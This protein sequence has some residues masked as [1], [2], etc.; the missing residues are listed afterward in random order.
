L[1]PYQLFEKKT[2]MYFRIISIL[3]ISFSPFCFLSRSV[4]ADL[5]AAW[6]FDEGSGTT[7]AAAF[8]SVNGTLNGSSSFVGTGISG[9]AVSLSSAGNGFVDMGNN[10]S[11]NGNTT[12]SIV[13]WVRLNQGDTNGYIVSGRHQATVV[14][15]YFLAVNN[16]GSGSG[17]VTGGG[18][19]YQSYPN[20]V[21]GNLGIND[22]NWHMLVG[23]HDFATS[24]SR[25]YVNG[26][27]RDSKPYNAFGLSNANFAVGGILNA[28]GNQMVGSYNGMVD[29]VSIWDH[30]LTGT[31][32]MYLF[33]NPGSLTTVP[34][35]SSFGLLSGLGLVMVRRE[36]KK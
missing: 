1:I 12:F 31:E 7:A 30:A 23:V 35:P 13:T 4:H 33:D 20:P 19:F 26:I 28:A 24:E 15:G 3:L 6:H 16:A 21:S 18:M 9:G 17:E 25:L 34:E 22:G 14:S 36:R 2:S 8:G 29:E 10:F 5:V 32:V 27:L 11:L